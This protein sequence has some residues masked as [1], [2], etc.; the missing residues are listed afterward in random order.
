MASDKSGL[1]LSPARSEHSL[2]SLWRDAL[3]DFDKTASEKLKRSIFQP[4]YSSIE[5]VLDDLQEKKEMFGLN[6]KSGGKLSRVR[7]AVSDHF[8]VIERAVSFVGFSVEV[9]SQVRSKLSCFILVRI[10][11][12]KKVT[13]LA[14]PGAVIVTGLGWVAKVLPVFQC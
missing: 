3:S 1:S 4:Q 7:S 10:L 6:R 8:P 12:T 5:D 9:A 13:P 14:A 2:A 11:T